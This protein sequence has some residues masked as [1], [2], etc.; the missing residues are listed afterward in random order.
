MGCKDKGHR[1]EV[2]FPSHWIKGIYHQHGLLLLVL[3]VI[4]GWIV[5]VRYPHW[6]VPHRPP[7][8]TVLFRRRSH[9]QPTL[10]V[11]VVLPSFRGR[12]CIIYFKSSSRHSIILPVNTSVCISNRYRLKSHTSSYITT[13]P[14]VQPAMLLSCHLICRLC[15]VSPN[16][17]IKGISMVGS[18][19]SGSKQYPPIVFC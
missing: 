11:G 9:G 2:L 12:V 14:P 8:C 1:G 7:F 16:C 4:P 15:S 18:F 6:R 17:P 5:F 3:A 10:G 13:M 19:T